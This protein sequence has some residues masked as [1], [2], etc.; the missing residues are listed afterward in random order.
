M[1]NQQ[2]TVKINY[3]LKSSENCTI[4]KPTT[5]DTK[6]NTYDTKSNIYDTMSNVKI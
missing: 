6:S 4:P 5:C 1:F 2:L 3:S